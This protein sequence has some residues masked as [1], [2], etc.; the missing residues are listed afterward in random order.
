MLEQ[1]GYNVEELMQEL[2]QQGE[3]GER[4]NLE[5]MDPQELKEYL[6]NEEF[7]NMLEQQGYDVKEIMKQVFQK[8][9]SAAQMKGHKTFV[10]RRAIDTN[11]VGFD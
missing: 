4:F 3:E 5:D 1:Q 10:C 2:A 8:R 7:R 11:L 9:K 6:E